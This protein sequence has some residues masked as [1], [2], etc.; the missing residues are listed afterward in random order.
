MAHR[1]VVP[2]D[3]TAAIQ[4]LVTAGSQGMKVYRIRAS[5]A[6]SGTIDIYI[7]RANS[8]VGGSSVPVTALD[9]PSPAAL[10]VA[11]TSPTGY[12]SS[13]QLGEWEFVGPFH[14]EDLVEGGP[15]E[16]GP[17]DSLSFA[18]SSNTTLRIYIEE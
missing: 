14:D 11:V 17:G 1:Y 3:V 16:V 10:T 8:V 18:P 12:S 9:D 15:I 6:S 2:V 7:D 4:A 5:S 13:G